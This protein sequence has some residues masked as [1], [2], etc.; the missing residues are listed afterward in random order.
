MSKR[1]EFWK[2]FREGMASMF[3]PSLWV[4]GSMFVYLTIVTV[5]GDD[6]I[7]TGACALALGVITLVG[8]WIA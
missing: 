3:H 7:T 6:P 5:I 2:G 8:I 1:R 4:G